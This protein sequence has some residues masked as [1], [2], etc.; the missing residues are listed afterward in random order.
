MTEEKRSVEHNVQQPHMVVV[1]DANTDITSDPE[2]GPESKVD[3]APA[4]EIEYEYITGIKL[5]LVMVAI[6]LGCFLVLL[7]TSIITTV[8]RSLMMECQLFADE[9]VQ[10]NPSNYQ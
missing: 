9:S 6:T 4:V 10:G 1:G 5:I 7:D 2:R 3:P 8:C